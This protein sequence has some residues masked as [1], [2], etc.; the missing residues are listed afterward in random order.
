MS[1][2]YNNLSV[3]VIRPDDGRHTPWVDAF[4]QAMPAV[5][6]S[7]LS[8][9]RLTLCPADLDITAT[10]G[11]VPIDWLFFASPNAVNG[12]LNPQNAALAR[13]ARHAQVAT[14][15]TTSAQ[16]A[17]AAGWA[18]PFVATTHRAMAGED[19]AQVGGG[20]WIHAWAQWHQEH[21]PETPLGTLTVLLPQSARA[22]P[23]TLAALQALGLRR[24]H[25]TTVYQVEDLAPS[26][27]V[28]LLTQHVLVQPPRVLVFTSPEGVRQV[29]TYIAPEALSPTTQL[30]AMGSSTRQAVQV[31]FPSQPCHCPEFPQLPSVVA[32]VQ[33]LCD[34]NQ[35]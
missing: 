8:L 34:A 15:G 33:R 27:A 4:Q 12:L 6:L 31:A 20:S 19:P 10:L 18:V 16:A 5:A 13:L 2:P 29:A 7:L 23:E 11:N 25:H 14:I 1:T 30:V 26:Q 22:R 17:L 35:G 21:F 3:V 9:Q 24:V 32:L 28:S